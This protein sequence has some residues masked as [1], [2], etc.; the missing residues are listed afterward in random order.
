MSTNAEITDIV[1]TLKETEGSQGLAPRVKAQL[2]IQGI[3]KIIPVYNDTAEDK[4][5]LGYLLDKV[6]QYLHD[7]ETHEVIAKGMQNL[8][9]PYAA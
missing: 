5:T 4:E 8:V 6:Q 7:P 2:A 3:R 1:N 9:V